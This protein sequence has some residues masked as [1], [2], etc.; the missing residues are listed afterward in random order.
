MTGGEHEAQKIVADV[1]VERGI[2]AR[3]GVA[4]LRFDLARELL[5][6]FRVQLALAQAVEGAVL[7][8]GHEPGAGV[9][10]NARTRPGLE[11]CDQRVLR[12]LLG[13]ADVAHHARD[14]GDDLRRLDP[15][16][17][18]DR[19]VDRRIGHV[20]D[21]APAVRCISVKPAAA[22]CTSGGKSPNSWTWRTSISSLSDMG[23]R[24]AHAIASSF[25]LTS[26]IQ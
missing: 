16:D 9:V 23:Q 13:E 8:G 17:R 20:T 22:S 7:G 10:G 3:H 2:D 14:A 6:L 1:V 11:G 19:L 15:K 26:I 18:V 4:Q 24:D 25:D 12:E 21:R 5:F